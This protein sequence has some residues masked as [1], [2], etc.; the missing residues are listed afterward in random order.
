MVLR[1]K[2]SHI[3]FLHLYHHIGMAFGSYCAA[4]FFA[5]GHH[6]LLGIVNSFVHSVMYFYY[7]LTS[8]KP[9]LKQ[10]IWWKKHLTQLQ[11]V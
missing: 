6:V 9:E 1:K 8:F 11:M 10:S 5:G 7:F 3:S 4:R 2:Q